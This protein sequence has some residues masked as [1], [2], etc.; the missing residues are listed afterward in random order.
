MNKQNV[1]NDFQSAAEYLID[2]NFCQKSQLAIQGGSNGG[3]LVGACV[4]QRP[5]LFQAAISQVGVLDMLRF[6][7]FTIGSAWI[8]DYGCPDEEEHFLNLLKYSPLH[9]VRTPESPKEAYP[10][11]L[12]STADHDDRVSPLHS[13]KFI[14]ALQYAVKDSSFQKNPILLRVYTKS[15][16]GFGN[17]NYF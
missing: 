3:L 9:N 1:F 16:H 5:D 7:K 4:N 11:L 6:H 17:Y 8:S 2:N 12:V 15:G 13:L 14:A 10:S